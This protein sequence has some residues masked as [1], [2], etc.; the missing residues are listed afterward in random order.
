MKLNNSAFLIVFVMLA[1]VVM[2]G[3]S[4]TEVTSKVFSFTPKEEKELITKTSNY[5]TAENIRI[6]KDT[7][8]IASFK[9][10]SEWKIYDDRGKKT[11]DIKN[12]QT[13]TIDFKGI[14]PKN[15]KKKITVYLDETGEILGYL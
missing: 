2:M 3:C 12:V 8:K 6:D 5:L 14:N 10:G 1:S 7:A 11:K 9:S 4:T 13:I 15:N